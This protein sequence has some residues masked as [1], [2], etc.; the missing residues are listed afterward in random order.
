MFNL[1]KFAQP[2]DVIVPVVGSKFQ[3]DHKK[4]SLSESVDDGWYTVTLEGNSASIKSDYPVVPYKT[5]NGYTHNNQVIFQNFDVAKRKWKFDVQKPLNFNGAETFS[6]VQ[7]VVWEDGNV[8]YVEP[9]YNDL[10]IYEVQNAFEDEISIDKVKGVTPELQT[11]YLFHSLERERQRIAIAEAKAAAEKAQ[12]E[13]EHARLMQ[14]VGYRLTHTFEQAG[15]QL[16]RYSI[17][18]NH[19]IADWQIN[20]GQTFNSVINRN[21]WMIEQ[22]GYCMSN[23]DSRHSVTSVVKTAVE[24]DNDGLI[25][26]T[27]R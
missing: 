4:F 20:S 22:A 6:A 11:L 21:T 10:L 23:D 25:Y 13:A 9:N 1:E 8:Y 24:Y 18:G 5:T 7:V 12:A 16:I 19:I 17:K 14:D 2:R 27:R 3:T 26:K 15:A